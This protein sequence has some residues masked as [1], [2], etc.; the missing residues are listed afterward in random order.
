M[1]PQKKQNITILYLST[2]LSLSL[3]LQ[4]CVFTKTPLPSAKHPNITLIPEAWEGI[5]QINGSE[6]APLVGEKYIE[7]K[8][9][10]PHRL[11]R[12]SYK[13]FTEDML[14]KHPHPEYFQIIGNFLWY[15]NE[16]Q[17]HKLDSLKSRSDLSNEDAQLKKE[18]QE[19]DDKVGFHQVFKLKRKGKFYIYDEKLENYLDLK[20]GT[21]KAFPYTKSWE[22]KDYQV[23]LKQLGSNYY[24]NVRAKMF[25]KANKV[26]EK[27]KEFKYD[28]FQWFTIWMVDKGPGIAI[29]IV[30][31][32]SLVSHAE[33]Y[34][35]I[36]PIQT[37]TKFPAMNPSKAAL[38]QMEKMAGF[39]RSMEY[40]KRTQLG[41]KPLPATAPVASQSIIQYWHVA[42]V[43][44]ALVSFMILW[45][46]QWLVKQS[47]KRKI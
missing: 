32:E 29:K 26:D 11:V 37:D 36:T 47:Q 38:M 25:D 5:Y 7:I 40:L 43:L 30:S 22:E 33:R 24:L 3:L 44:V 13:V 12:T 28:W 20:K 23:N 4:G 27:N 35:K 14:Q 1:K 9:L 46:Q 16:A 41:G 42:I 6:K 18:L 8:L 15:Y 10:D 31:N 34:Q 45:L 2:W 19:Y 17:K 21:L 39:F